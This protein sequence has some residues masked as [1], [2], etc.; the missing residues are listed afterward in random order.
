MGRL[1]FVS[2]DRVGPE[3]AGPGVRYVELARQL[4]KT[5]DVLVAAPTGSGPVANGPEVAVYDPERPQT[6]RSLLAGREVVVAP[7]LPPRLMRGVA[8]SSRAWIVDLYN[9]EPFEGLEHQRTRPRFERKVR[10]VVR[11]DRVA[12]A[13]RAGSAFVCASER[14]RDM[15]LGFLAA[16]RRLDS[17]LYAR[18]AELRTLVDVVPFGLPETEPIAGAEPVLRGPVFP[19]D[20]RIMVWNGGLWDWL[21]PLTVLRALA[22]LRADDPAWG[23]VF[24]GTIRPS[25]REQ[26]AMTERA[27]QLADELGLREA[28]AVHFRPGWTPYAD[29]ASLLLECDMG[30]SAHRAS[31]ETRFSYRSR[32]LDFLWTRLPIVSSDGD[33]WAERIAA[34][35]LGE[36]A[37][38]GD[39]EAF[40]AAAKRVAERGRPAFAGA[41]AEA[42]SRETW[43]D[44]VKPLARLVET[45]SASPG[46]HG[47]LARTLYDARHSTVARAARAR[48][49]TP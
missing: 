40:A 23:L 6:L 44:A 25:H 2:P 18:D 13:V 7:P 12:F 20:T 45:V 39:P 36:V 4:A 38:P 49:R 30:V 19:V 5:H 46:R 41:L 33:E 48:G 15:W 22:L 21:D 14:Q 37:P 1:I 32:M 34:E 27:V 26:M 31:L 9:P 42:A 35:R 47:R 17:D 28:G 8:T 10:D 29:R 43:S 11:I 16:S 24:M 3:M